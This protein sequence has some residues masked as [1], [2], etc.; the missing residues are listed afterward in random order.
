PGFFIY[1]CSL[2]S[3][4]SISKSTK[5]S[6]TIRSA[7]PVTS[8]R[9]SKSSPRTLR[10]SFGPERIDDIEFARPQFTHSSSAARLRASLA[11]TENRLISQER[12]LKHTDKETFN[13]GPSESSS[14]QGLFCCRLVLKQN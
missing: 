2:S 13:H 8:P 9:A 3:P 7:S 10:A 14:F 5:T 11:R 12:I 6:S 1:A 4:S